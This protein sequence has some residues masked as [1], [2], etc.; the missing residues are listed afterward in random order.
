MNRG[1][2][3]RC[4]S[5][6]MLLWLWCR[7]ATAASIRPLA[8]DPPHAKGVAL[9]KTDRQKE[10]AIESIIFNGKMLNVFPFRLRCLLSPRNIIAE[11]TVSAEKQET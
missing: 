5:D 8:W 1:V 11:T 6:L 3:H 4:G 7:P 2:G 10:R 9:K